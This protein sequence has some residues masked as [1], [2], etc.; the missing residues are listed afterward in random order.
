MSFISALKIRLRCILGHSWAQYVCKEPWKTEVR[1]ILCGIKRDG[2]FR[3]DRKHFFSFLW[4]S[5][6]DPG[7]KNKDV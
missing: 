2:H 4:G 6:S 7:D 1:C 3:L 5:F